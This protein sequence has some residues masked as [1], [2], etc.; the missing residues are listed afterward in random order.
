MTAVGQTL[1]TTVD[2]SNQTKLEMHRRMLRIRH[3][4]EY[5]KG[6]MDAAEMVGG[7]HLSVGQEA[8]IVGACMVLRDDDYMVGTHRSH[9]HPI[10]KGAPIK[11]LMAELLGRRT[12][13][14]KGKGGSMHL[15]DF[16][17]GSLGETSI[18]ASGLPIAVGGG[19]SAKL[20]GTDQVS[21]AF[22]GDGAA[23]EG[24][25]HESLNLA[26]I[27]NLPV[28][29][30]CENN[31][32]GMTTS[33]EEVSAVPNVADRATAYGIP[34]IVVDGQDV[35]A[36][37]AVTQQAV[38]RARAGEGPSLIEAK[39]HRQTSHSYRVKEHRQESEVD[40]A[41]QR[42]P[43]ALFRA[44]LLRTGVASDADLATMETEVEAEMSEGAAF[45]RASELPDPSE[46]F[47]DI[48]ATDGVPPSGDPQW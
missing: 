35:L 32:Y 18:V 47:T 6:F 21:L 17:I 12:G 13:I 20:R 38:Q 19:L 16:K 15:A 10:A 48:Y 26:A 45:A 43:I 40:L 30:Y 39:T 5:V 3:F 46:A 14:N 4:E 37:W 28:I 8:A 9:G 7:A 41:R 11:P 24:A 23:Q 31:Q 27:W 36:C 22:F 42:D 1:S 44:E 33:F 29:F 25:F 34:G 2:I